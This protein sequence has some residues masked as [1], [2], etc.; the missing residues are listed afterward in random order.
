MK[1]VIVGKH[2]LDRAKNGTKNGLDQFGHGNEYLTPPEID[3]FGTTDDWQVRVVPNKFPIVPVHEI[4]IYDTETSLELIFQMYK[5]RF[6]AHQ[7]EGRVIIFVNFGPASGAT[8]IH[9][10]SQLTV[11]PANMGEIAPIPEITNI[12]LEQNNLVAYCPDRSEYSYEVWIRPKNILADFAKM[13]DEDLKDL[14][15]I[16]EQI[17]NKLR[18]LSDSYNYYIE[19]SPFWFLRIFPRV[20]IKGSFELA[21][22]IAVNIIDPASAAGE[23]IYNK[24]K[25]V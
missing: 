25:G 20:S 1:W 17:I 6:L 9:P 2:R 8:L 22:G 3:R 10:H 19:T 16:T 11:V 21:T 12:I 7:K 5:R 23:L 24:T 14:S 15:Q 13:S 4:I 18:K